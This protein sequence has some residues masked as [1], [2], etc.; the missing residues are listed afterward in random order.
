MNRR[1]LGL[2]ILIILGISGAMAYTTPY[3]VS[4]TTIGLEFKGGYEIL[5][6]AESSQSG[7]PID[8]DTLLKTANMLASRA[9]S[10]GVSEPQVSIEGDHEIRVDLAGVS[11]NEQVRAIMDAQNGLP[12]KLTEK[13]SET[14]GGVLGKS[15]LNSTFWAGIIAL[16]IILGFMIMFYR[17][18]GLVASFT[19]ITYLWLLLLMFNVFHGVLSL[20]AVVTFVLGMGIAVDAN[21]I[22]YERIREELRKG[23]SV[24]EALKEG[25]HNA[26]HIIMHANITTAIAAIVLFFAGI[27]PIKG[28]A[29][30][31]ILSIIVSIVSNVFLSRIL[32]N[33][34]VK[35]EIVK[36]Q[37]FF[38][39]RIKQSTESLKHFSFVKH[40]YKFIAISVAIAGVGA[41]VLFTTELNYDI[42]FKAGTALDITLDK[43]ITQDTATNI[44]VD[45]GI[46]PATVA[47]GGQNNNQIAARFDNVL[48]SN[49]VNAI[50][51]DFKANYTKNVVY[52]ENTY[53]P[54]VAQDLAIKAVYV[55]LAAI[56]A[57]V[58]FVTIRFS[59]KFAMA[60]AVSVLNSAFFVLAM[61]AILKLEIDVTFIA[62]ILTVI[63]FATYNTIVIF[64]RIRENMKNFTGN[65]QD[66]FGVV[67]NKSIWQMMTR[68][69]NTVI[70]VVIA[71]VCVYLFGAEPLHNFALAILFGLICGT[72][73]SICIGAPIYF[74]L[75]KRSIKISI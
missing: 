34:L 62:A 64:D 24:T 47:I 48:Q 31:L 19:V 8:R 54:A 51:N 33:L 6:T 9:N 39:I 52:E 69:I 25:E 26:F 14:V 42:D 63:G 75:K 45:A 5:Y 66:E 28:F 68:S 67:I 71:A 10:L 2:F 11:S 23:K 22:A 4:H 27:G 70:T 72:Y 29:F 36:K 50:M 21:I 18:V 56:A 73:S 53:D 32:L 74:T 59:W 41:F 7:K 60:S 43:S 17:G 58:T 30:T 55:I 35:G 46:P 61:F 38:G 15:D 20:A 44:M 3:L 40:R 1:S 57:I 13:Y 65:S 12:L 37:S 49:D 16:G